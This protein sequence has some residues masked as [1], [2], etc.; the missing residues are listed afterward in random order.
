M[1]LDSLTAAKVER[2]LPDKSSLYMLSKYFDALSDGTRLK[3]LSALTV[4]SMCV[5]DLAYL[6]GINQTTASHQLRILR[7]SGIVECSRQGKVIFYSVAPAVPI[8][9]EAAVTAALDR[10]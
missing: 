1:L 5:T 10:P 7:D 8:V 4:S 6:V 2:S 3:I 9:M